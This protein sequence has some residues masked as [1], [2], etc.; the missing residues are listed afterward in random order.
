MSGLKLYE[1]A[2]LDINTRHYLDVQYKPDQERQKPLFQGNRRQDHPVATVVNRFHRISVFD[3][4]VGI[5]RTG[6]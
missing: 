3:I 5:K 2:S 6:L 1:A 4:N